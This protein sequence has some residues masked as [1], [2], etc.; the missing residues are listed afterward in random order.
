MDK[1]WVLAKIVK[2]G[3]ACVN[4]ASAQRYLAPELLMPNFSHMVNCLK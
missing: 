4:I 3:K 1:I 2:N